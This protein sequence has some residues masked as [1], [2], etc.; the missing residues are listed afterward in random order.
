MKIKTLGLGLAVTFLLAAPV[1][2]ADKKAQEAEEMQAMMAKAKEFGTPGAEHEILKPLEGNWT[3]ASRF[4]MK[5]GDKE[6][7]SSGTSSM[8]WTMGGRFLKQEFKGDWM[9]QAFEG[10]GYLGYDK[11]KKEYVSVWMDNMAT[12]MFQGTGQYDAA[13]KTLTESGNFSCPAT[14]EKDM[15]FRTEWKIV[16]NDKNIY[17]MY[18]KDPAGKEFKSMEIVYKRAK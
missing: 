6:Q 2:A 1:Q 15:W 5:P 17:S 3:A 18:M 9:G 12:G 14:G 11:M 10:L 13:T 4:W 16:N 8:S 7:K